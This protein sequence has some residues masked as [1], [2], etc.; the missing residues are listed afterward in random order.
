MP[1]IGI[2][3][4]NNLVEPKSYAFS[5]TVGKIFFGI[6]NISGFN[7]FELVNLVGVKNLKDSYKSLNEAFEHAGII[8]H[9]K[10]NLSFIDASKLNKKNVKKML[11]FADG[12]LIPGG[13]G[14]R[15]TDGKI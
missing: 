15:G 6:L 10:V 13:F 7:I 1:P 4:P 2:E 3:S 8:N 11:S 14:K 9:T 5:T 12:I